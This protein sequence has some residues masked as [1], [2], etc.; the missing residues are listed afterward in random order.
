MTDPLAPAILAAIDAGVTL[1]MTPTGPRGDL[2]IMATLRLSE[3]T[4][5]EATRGIVRDQLRGVA[6]PAGD[7]IAWTVRDLTHAILSAPAV[8]DRTE[9]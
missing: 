9:P 6:G 8:P 4:R 3:A 5:L 1:T 2:T 7:L